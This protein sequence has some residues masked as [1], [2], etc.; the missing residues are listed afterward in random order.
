M[1]PPGTLNV[2]PKVGKLVLRVICWTSGRAVK[3]H[4]GEHTIAFVALSEKEE[5]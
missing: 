2:H 4:G 3:V 1:G 5:G